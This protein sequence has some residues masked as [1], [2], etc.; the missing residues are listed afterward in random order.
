MPQL[1]FRIEGSEAVP[2]SVA[3]TLAFKLHVDNLDRTQNIHSVALHCQIQIEATRRRYDAGEQ[4]R[5]LDLYGEPQ[6][7]SQT[8]RTM[9]W[10]QA[11]VTVPSFTGTALVDLLVP[12]TFDFNVAATKYFAALAEGE[13]P[14][15]FLFSGTIFY[16]DETGALQIDQISWE[17]ESSY[18]LPI[19]VWQKMM[20]IYYPN[21]AWLSISRDVFDQVCEYKRHH[22][23]PTWEQ[24]LERLLSSAEEK[25][26][27]PL[28]MRVAS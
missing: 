9:L 13:V 11:N 7:W 25:T 5:L 22:G 19:T 4:D 2:V 3:P 27:N 17:K 26:E 12:C 15:C 20:D 24:T 6:R 10:T 21:T 14:L 1:S 16:E 28:T 23:I 18:R 8:L